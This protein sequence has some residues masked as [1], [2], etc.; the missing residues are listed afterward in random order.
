MNSIGQA[1]KNVFKLEIRI[2]SPIELPKDAYD[3]SRDQYEGKQ[4]IHNL[5]EKYGGMVLGVTDKDI[6]AKGLNFIFGQAQLKGR[7]A[8]ISLHRLYPEFYKKPKNIR[9]LME[10]AQKEG[11][12]EVGH[13]LLGLTH[14]M[15]PNCVMNFSNTIEDVDR[16]SKN[17]CESCKTIEK[18]KF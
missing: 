12:H 4:L 11:V 10:R 15:N 7:I 8:I 3:E 13:A 9:L 6:Y 5:Y 2:T 18:L 1:L 14:C 17:L 16:K